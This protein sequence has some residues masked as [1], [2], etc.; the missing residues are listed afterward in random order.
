M[1]ES[2]ETVPRRGLKD[3]SNE[4]NLNQLRLPKQTTASQEPEQTSTLCSFPMVTIPAITPR[5]ALRRNAPE[6]DNEDE[7]VQERP[8]KKRG[9]TLGS[10]NKKTLEHSFECARVLIN[11]HKI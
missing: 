2:P 1:L 5:A 8:K 3:I 6:S 4:L 7:L 10:K 11:K 9:R